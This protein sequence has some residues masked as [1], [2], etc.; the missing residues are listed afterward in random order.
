MLQELEPLTLH[1]T[2]NEY[3]GHINGKKRL[4]KILRKRGFITFFEIPTGPI[5]TEKGERT[6]TIDVWGIWQHDDH[7]ISEI[8]FEVDGKK[9]HQSKINKAR[10]KFR[11]RVHWQ[12]QQ[13]PTIRLERPWLS[14]RNKVSDYDILNEINWQLRTKFGIRL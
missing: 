7:S 2:G 11:D 9:G 4:A 8:A 6:Y 10:D 12:Y 5:Q 1:T 14:G 13:L 3:E